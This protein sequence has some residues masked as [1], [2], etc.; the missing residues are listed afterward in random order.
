[1][2]NFTQKFIGLLTLMFAI[3][4]NSFAQIT[5]CQYDLTLIS[6]FS[7]DWDD[8]ISLSITSSTNELVFALSLPSV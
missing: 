7:G 8:E 5:S 3:S 6:T 2:K 4:F 1:M